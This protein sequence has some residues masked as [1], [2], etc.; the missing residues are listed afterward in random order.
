[1]SLLRSRS[2]AVLA[3]AALLVG[4][5]SFGAVAGGLVTSRD[6]KNDTV[7]SADVKNNTLRLVDINDRAEAQLRGAKGDQGVQGVQGEQG[8]K[9]EPGKD[10]QNDTQVR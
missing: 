6:I 5:S 4:A 9:G 8:P 7:S 3:G 10:G 1:M 2:V